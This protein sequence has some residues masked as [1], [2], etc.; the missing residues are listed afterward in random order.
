M[1]EIADHILDIAENSLRAGAS[2][3]KIVVNEDVLKDKLIITIKD[4]GIGMSK[5][6]QTKTLN[7]F[8]TT[9]TVRNV[10]LGIPLLSQ[11]ACATDGKLTIKSQKGKGTTLLAEFGLSHV[12]RQPMGDIA[13]TIIALII[14]RPVTKLT[15]IH[16]FNKKTFQISTSEIKKQIDDIPI[17][18]IAV[19]SEVK[20]M[21]I[22][23][24]KGI[25]STL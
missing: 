22:A 3:I 11:M 4:D 5:A 21:I 9:K 7:P 2:D 25:G 1:L 19:L 14:E 18:N 17:D 15:Y 16:R 10:G 13:G 6:E 24:I 23:G 8:Y 20:K 12:D